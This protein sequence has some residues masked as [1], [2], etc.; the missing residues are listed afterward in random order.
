ME[1]YINKSPEDGIIHPSSFSAGAGFFFVKKKDK[2]LHR[3]TSTVEKT[4]EKPV[5]PSTDFLRV[6]AASGGDGVQQTGFT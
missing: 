2:S 1:E 6:R 4:C 3:V 5:H